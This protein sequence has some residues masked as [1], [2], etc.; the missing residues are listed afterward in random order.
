MESVFN[1]IEN[2]NPGQLAVNGQFS[3]GEVVYKQLSYIWEDD[4]EIIFL[5]ATASPVKVSN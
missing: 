1:E 5:N 3:H 2:L 4:G